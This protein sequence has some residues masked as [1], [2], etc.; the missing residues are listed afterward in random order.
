MFQGLKLFEGSFVSRDWFKDSIGSKIQLVQGFNY[1]K[2]T[3]G[4][5]IKFYQGFNLFKG[6]MGSRVQGFNGLN[7]PIAPM[8]Y[9][10]I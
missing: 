4:S 10:L 3:I 2:D 7:V 6:S 8:V 9:Y 1:F 5:R